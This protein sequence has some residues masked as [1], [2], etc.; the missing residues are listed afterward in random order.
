VSEKGEVEIGNWLVSL[1]N[2]IRRKELHIMT[3]QFISIATLIPALDGEPTQLLP[4]IH[5][6]RDE[7]HTPTLTHRAVRISSDLAEYV[8]YDPRATLAEIPTVKLPVDPES[9]ELTPLPY[10]AW[11]TWHST[12]ANYNR[13]CLL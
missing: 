9:I 5:V 1:F 4:S 10:D 7:E 12:L 6:V 13:L 3:Q 11:V 8:G 2:T